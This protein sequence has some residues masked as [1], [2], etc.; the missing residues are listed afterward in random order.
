M[1]AD[2]PPVFTNWTVF[3]SLSVIHSFSEL[4]KHVYLL[5]CSVSHTPTWSQPWIWITNIL[6]GALA[7]YKQI[8]TYF[9][10]PTACMIFRGFKIMDFESSSS[11]F[12]FPNYKQ[13][14]CSRA[15]V[16]TFPLWPRRQIIGLS[17]DCWEVSRK[18]NLANNPNKCTNFG[19]SIFLW[20]I[21][22]HH[23]QNRI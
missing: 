18:E 9:L 8:Q 22:S 2:Y 16:D 19:T 15:D 20:V 13:R 10:S 12:S 17:F 21:I 4:I 6:K 7:W 1:W 11:F 14:L 3:S 23:I 5:L